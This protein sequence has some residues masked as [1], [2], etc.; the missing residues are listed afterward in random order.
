MMTLKRFRVT[1]FRSIDDS[2]WIET[3]DVTA[4][5]G[6]N[7]AGKTNIL[8]PLWKLNP[9]KEGDIIPTA[10]YPR[11]HYSALRNQKPKP[12]FIRAVFEVDDELAAK[13][14][15][16]TA[17]PV[18]DIR[19]VEVTKNFD[20]KFHVDFP[21]VR[22]VTSVA[23]SSVLTVL[24]K[25][26]R[27]LAAMTAL[28]TEEKLKERLDSSLR[29]ATDLVTA[30]DLGSEELASVLAILDKVKT[31][32]AP[33]TSTVIPRFKQVTEQIRTQHDE[34]SRG[35]PRD[36]DA[37]T[38]MVVENLPKFVYYSTYGNLDSEIYL[39]HVI[40]N[41]AR[42]DLGAREQAKAR[43]LKVLFEFVKLKPEE[44]LELGQE[45]SG[46]QPT[47]E[48][49]ASIAEKKKQRSILLQSASTLLTTRFRDWWKQGEYRFRFEADGNHFRIGC[50]SSS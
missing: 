40:Q 46:R 12:V 28:K 17:I 14:A 29:R 38:N 8:L 37:V 24:Q 44:I 3:D 13:L 33:K 2:D 49:I 48:E 41:M 22:S 5:I 31:D 7:E 16:E 27:D 47:E 6:T 26:A 32:S 15:G 20:N 18:D 42:N 50:G 45:G 25:G 9:A 34:I 36:V 1:N 10:D 4:L 43:T 11:K 21:D 30:D 19:T 39:P 23:K 35:H